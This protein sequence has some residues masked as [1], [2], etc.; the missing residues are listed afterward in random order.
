[1]ST[2]KKVDFM[3]TLPADEGAPPFLEFTIE[4]T[5]DIGPENRELLVGLERT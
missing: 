2:D 1:M 4:A 3:F 5:R